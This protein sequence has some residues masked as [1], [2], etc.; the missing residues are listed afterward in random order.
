MTVAAVARRIVYNGSGTTGPFT[1]NFRVIAST[2]IAVTKIDASDVETVITVGGGASQYTIT[3]TNYG[4]SGGSITLG[5]ALAVGERLLIKG[6]T[7]LTQAVRYANQGA[8]FGERHEGSFDKLTLILQE[9][10][11]TAERSIR[12][13]DLDS[14]VDGELP[15]ISAN[16]AVVTN[17]AGDGFDLVS[18]ATLGG[19]IDT[20]F[21]GLAAEDFIKYNGTFWVNRTPTQVRTDLGLVIGTNVQ[22]YNVN[23]AGIAGLT[24]A[25]D[26]VSYFTGAGGASAL[27]T[28][29]SYGRSVVAV[30]NEAAF[31]ALVNLEA[32]TDFNAYSAR[33]AE[34]SGLTPTAATVIAGNGAAFVSNTLG[35]GLAVSGTT[36]LSSFGGALLHLQDQKAAGTNGGSSTSGSWETRTLNTE[37]TDEIGSTLSSNTFT[38]PAGTY[39]IEA[40]APARNADPHQIRLYN[41]TDAAAVVYGTSE[42]SNTTNPSVTRSFI[43]GRFTIA[44]AKTFRLEHRVT[45]SSATTGYGEANNFGGTEIYSDVRVW[46]L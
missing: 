13:N 15:E 44:G 20:A 43:N 19:S 36:I 33:L 32:G 39:W 28:F 37:V 3:L 46:K 23:L 6:V 12:I 11:E 9:S 40:S 22:A 34:V 7:P 27:A 2:D 21:S 29:T 16:K 5:T 14:G 35:A 17:S 30:A 26:R 18:F 41:V 4:Q 8:F 1:F 24:S 38:L 42:M 25:A 10:A 31:K 45:A